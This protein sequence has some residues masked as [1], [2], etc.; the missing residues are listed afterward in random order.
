MKVTILSYC[1]FLA[2]VIMKYEY[3]EF[4]IVFQQ[5]S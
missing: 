3:K 1:S 4:L 2:E 5:R